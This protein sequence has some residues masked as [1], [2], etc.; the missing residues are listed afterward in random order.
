VGWFLAIRGVL[1]LTVPKAYD[2][3]GNAVYSSGAT[4][5]I[6]AVFLCP[7]SA[8]LYLTFVGWRPHRTGS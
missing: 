2:A 8:G 3:A 5:V 1:L 4:A 7:A 6:W